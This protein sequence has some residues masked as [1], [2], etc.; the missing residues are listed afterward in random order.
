[1]APPI[2]GQ[3]LEKSRSQVHI[4][5]DQQLKSPYNINTVLRRSPKKLGTGYC[6]VVSPNF[7]K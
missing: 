3:D 5:G 4:Y 7:Q 2:S 1:M 6:L